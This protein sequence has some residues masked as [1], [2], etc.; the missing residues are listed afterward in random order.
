MA[1][2]TLSGWPSIEVA[3]CSNSSGSNPNLVCASK[4]RTLSSLPASTRPAIK[5]PTMADDDE[6]KPEQMGTLFFVC[7]WTN[8]IG[9][10]PA[11]SNATL[12]ACRTRCLDSPF[13][14]IF[15][16][17]ILA[18]SPSALTENLSGCLSTVISFHMSTAIPIASKPGPKFALVAGTRTT[19][20]VRFLYVLEET[21]RAWAGEAELAGAAASTSSTTCS[22]SAIATRPCIR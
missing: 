3:R 20:L 15:D 7:T 2:A 8:G 22:G 12:S 21:A 14:S 10:S 13:G 6:P 11:Y 19:T 5:P 16:G 4:V 18:P 1:G 9:T 17:I